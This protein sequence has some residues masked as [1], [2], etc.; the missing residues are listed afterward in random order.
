MRSL[1]TRLV[2]LTAVG[3]AMVGWLWMLFE[4]LVWVIA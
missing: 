1:M 4:G 2:Y 3:V